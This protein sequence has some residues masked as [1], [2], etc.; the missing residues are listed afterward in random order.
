[1]SSFFIPSL[2]FEVEIVL[3]FFSCFSHLLRNIIIVI[4]I[5]GS[6]LSA[7]KWNSTYFHFKRLN[8]HCTWTIHNPSK[9]WSHINIKTKENMTSTGLTSSCFFL[10]FYCMLTIIQ[11]W[12]FGRI[13]FINVFRC[14][15]S[16]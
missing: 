12:I 9:I 14:F 5:T 16:L 8:Y 3:L 6:F 11:I 7:G 4:I 15:L 10:T 1:M 2:L 13:A